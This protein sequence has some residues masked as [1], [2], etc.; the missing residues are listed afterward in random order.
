M[1]R[2]MMSMTKER[3]KNDEKIAG[4]WKKMIRQL[5]EKKILRTQYCVF[6][7]AP[8]LQ[9]LYKRYCTKKVKLRP[10]KNFG[11]LRIPY[12]HFSPKPSPLPTH[13]TNTTPNSI[14]VFVDIFAE[15]IRCSHIGFSVSTVCVRCSGT[16][17]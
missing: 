13:T 15:T 4:K 9:C 16:R 11:S 5:K 8:R 12:T 14:P 2:M 1:M 7:L 10:H 6:T 17:G 3:K